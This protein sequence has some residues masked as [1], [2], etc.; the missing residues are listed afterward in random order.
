[1]TLYRAVWYEKGREVGREAGR[2]DLRDAVDRRQVT[3]GATLAGGGLPYRG[4]RQ[5]L[6][7]WEKAK[8][9]KVERRRKEAEEDAPSGLR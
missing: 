2:W 7:L 8:P 4:R 9:V 6:Q 5:G 3:R 1:M